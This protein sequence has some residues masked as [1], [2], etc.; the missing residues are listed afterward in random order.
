MDKAEFNRLTEL[1]MDTVYRVARSG[2]RNES[3][4]EDITQNT[5]LKLLQRKKL[6]NDDDHA[7]RWLI[8]V[9]VNEGN[10]LWRKRKHEDCLEATEEIAVSDDFTDNDNKLLKALAQLTPEYRQAV[11]LY[12]FEDYSTKEIAKLLNISDDTVR[13]RLSRARRKLRELLNGSWL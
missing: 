2:S 4:A 13:T 11:H 7:R 9:A 12:Y 1:Y 10:M 8:R 3:D 6:F 5:F